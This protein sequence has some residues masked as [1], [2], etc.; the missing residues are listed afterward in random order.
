MARWSVKCPKH[1]LAVLGVV[2]DWPTTSKLYLCPECEEGAV[3]P[4]LASDAI[5]AG[6]KQAK[7]VAARVDV[8]IDTPTED[9][10]P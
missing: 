4:A 7:P 10:K 9:A 1:P 2:R 6:F 5:T 3:G 8:P